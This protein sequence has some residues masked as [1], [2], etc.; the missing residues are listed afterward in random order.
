[1]TRLEKDVDELRE[2]FGDRLTVR[3]LPSGAHLIEVNGYKL[4]KGWD[5]E[6]ATI[7]FLA[8]PAYPGAQPD[9]FWVEPGPLRY[10]NGQT[11][12]NSNDSNLVPE[13]GQRG[14]WFSWHV[15]AWN[16]NTSTL[17]TFFRVI[18]K[19]LDPPR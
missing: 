1:M 2:T 6:V 3:A 12:Q 10:N 16:P 15:Q 13:V 19:R 11:P 9:C 17:M 7:I 18:E 14:T 5:R 4:P 8:P